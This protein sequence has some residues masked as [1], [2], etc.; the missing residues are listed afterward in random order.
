[1]YAITK[2]KYRPVCTLDRESR[3]IRIELKCTSNYICEYNG[4]QE[5]NYPARV[6]HSPEDG[7]MPFHPGEKVVMAAQQA[8][9]LVRLRG[10]QN[11]G[12]LHNQPEY[13]QACDSRL[14]GRQ[15]TMQPPL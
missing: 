1:M 10:D 14:Q 7:I 5:L 13:A 4:F 3:A 6:L 12:F 15:K 11:N 2:I 8:K 9:H